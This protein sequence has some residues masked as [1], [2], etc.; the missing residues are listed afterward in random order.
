MIISSSP[1]GGE[2]DFEEEGGWARAGQS[3]LD[4]ALRKASIAEGGA[5]VPQFGRERC[6]EKRASIVPPLDT[7]SSFCRYKH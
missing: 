7:I 4:I 1:A 3:V 6:T 5:K 2:S